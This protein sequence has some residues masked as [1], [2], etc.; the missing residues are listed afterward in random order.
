MVPSLY[1]K[2]VGNDGMFKATSQEV[3]K[4][5]DWLN[6]K[7]KRRLP[8]GYVFRLPTMAEWEY[9]AHAGV[10]DD[11]FFP[12]AL[13]TARESDSQDNLWAVI[14]RLAENKGVALTENQLKEIARSCRPVRMA[15]ANDWGIYDVLQPTYVLDVAIEGVNATNRG[16][17]HA[18]KLDGLA[19]REEPVD[20]LIYPPLDQIK[21]YQVMQKGGIVKFPFSV[22]MNSKGWATC[23]RLVLGPDLLKERGFAK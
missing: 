4:Y 7:F 1:F 13:A 17:F 6:E 9:A 11:H 19:P 5:C 18:L 21:K 22:N 8:K 3:Q 12:Y 14:R 20:P 16:N 15:S 2:V 23:F 10:G